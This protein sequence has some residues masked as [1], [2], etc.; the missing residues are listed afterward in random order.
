MA[1]RL[2]SLINELLDAARL[3]SGEVLELNRSVTD[4]VELVR[5]VAEQADVED[6][7][8]VIVESTET[9]LVGRWDAPRLERV[10]MNLVSN[11]TTYSPDQ[12]EVRIR[13]ATEERDGDRWA[14]VAVQDR[15]I[16]IPKSDLSRV[17]D[18][19]YRGGNVVDRFGGTGIG[20]FGVKQIVE[21]HAGRVTVESQVGLGST[22]T[23]WLPL[24]GSD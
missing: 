15:G 9:S 3:Q 21:Q 20:L 16:G 10:L 18:R 17:F 22:F 12:P 11:A 1:D 23:V 4:L 5:H 2:S 24:S 13:V 7:H 6:G 8:V 14:L 19:F